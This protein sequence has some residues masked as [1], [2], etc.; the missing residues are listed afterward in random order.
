MIR[1]LLPL[2]LAVLSAP[3]AWAFA[4]LRIDAKALHEQAQAGRVVLLDARPEEE[5]HKGH[6]PGARSAP[7]VKT[8]ENFTQDGR[9]ASLPKAQ[10][11]FSAVGLRPEDAVVVY[12]AGGML[13]A[14]R[15]LWLLEVYG[16]K[17][18]KL[19]E[20][21]VKA[22]R[23]QGLSLTQEAVKTAP[24]QYVPSINPKRLATRIT[25]LAASSKPSAFVI[26]D[27]RAP[28]HYAGQESEAPRFGHIPQAR[29]IAVANNLS[30]DGMRLKSRQE[31]S[32]LYKDLPKDKKI[33]TYCSVGLASSLEYLVLRELGYDVA[34]YDA[35]WKE[36]GND[37]SLPIVSPMAAQ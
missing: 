1:W 33:I 11:L 19:L 29:N 23:Q 3:A 5:Y 7:F 16:H 6:L 20:G 17:Q 26:L 25:T 9:M 31:L 37:A 15:V 8:F 28:S 30:A 32:E 34:N 36:W 27:A 21:G 4:D 14:A 13:H 24:S 10:A 35:S 22:W 12:D 18:V 2:L